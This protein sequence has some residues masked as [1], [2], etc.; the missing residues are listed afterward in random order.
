MK[1]QLAVVIMAGGAGTRFWPISTEE[2]PKQ[3]LTLFDK[4]SL[5][6]QSYDRV[7]SLVPPERIFVLTNSTFVDLVKEQLPNVPETNIIGEPIRRDTAAAVALSAL[8]CEQR[9]GPSVIAVLTA[10]HH[11]QPTSR[12]QQVLLSAAKGALNNTDALY[13]FGTNPTYPATCYGYL[14]LGAQIHVDGDIPH[15]QL[16]DF[17]EKPDEKTAQEYFGSQNYRWNSGMFVWTTTAILNELRLQLPDHLRHLEK[18]VEQDGTPQWETAIET[19]FSSLQPVSIDYGVMEHAAKV[20][21]VVADYAWNDVGG[22]LALENFLEKD[23]KSN[24]FRGNLHTLNARNNLCFCENTDEHI[25]LVG[26]EGMV[27]VR[28]GNKTLVVKRD[29]VEQVKQLVQSLERSLR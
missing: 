25:A 28:A 4:R 21:A 8:L 6:Q 23:S 7:S 12:F 22:W 24:A 2:C 3:F 27:V 15:F 18:A 5:L 13:T 10:D 19:A 20:N 14:H 17:K 16:L 11:I 9:L 1:E 29:C 26:V